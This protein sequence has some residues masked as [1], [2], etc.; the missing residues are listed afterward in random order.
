MSK[1][2]VRFAPSPT[3]HIHIGNTRVALL[4]ALFARREGGTFVLRFDDT[5]L[6]RS[7]Q[8][9]ADSIETDLAWLGI[10]P[11]VVVRQSERFDLYDDAAERLKALGR[12]YACYETPEELEFRRKRQLARGLPPIYDRAALKLTDEDRAKLEAE[13]R[14]PH[15]RFRLDHATVA[16]DDLV[17]GH[18][19]VD[20]GSLSD[21][22]LVREDGTYLYT[23]PSVV[24]DIALKITHVIRG[25]DHVT[26]TA[27]QIQI[28]EALGAKA[29]LFAHH[30]LLITASGEGL[31]KRLGHLSVKGLREAGLEPQAVASLAVLVGSAEAVRPVADLD[32]LARLIDFSHISRAPAK[33]DEHELDQLNARLI[34]EMSYETARPR[35][36]ALGADGGEAFWLAVRGNLGKLVDAAEWWTVVQGPIVPLITDRAFIEEARHLLPPEPWDGSTWKTWT[37]AVKIATGV[38]GKALFMPLRMALT[39]LDHGPE[40]GALLPLIGPERA[41]ARLSGDAA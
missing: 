7:K 1:P 33:F 26:N 17:R 40:L 25:E 29:P 19:H 8:E 24:D 13:G 36:A 32:E 12:L 18:A 15:W 4:N 3:G 34:H 6:A 9:Y 10:P 23:L 20:C 16:W 31:S 30:S 38:K 27:V 2:I 35:L 22:V 39:G 14:R 28:F 21:P 41:K 37:E 5:D 11:D